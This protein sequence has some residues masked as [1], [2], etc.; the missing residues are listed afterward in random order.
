MLTSE[1]SENIKKQILQQIE[2]SFPE[3]KKAQAIQQLNSMNQ[4]QLEQFILQNKLI[5]NMNQDQPCIFCQII[6]GNISSYKIAENSKAIAILE[7]NPI[8]KA[9]TIVIPKN[10]QDKN[11]KTILELSQE[12]AQQ[13]KK[14]F[15]PKDIQI[16]SSELF[17]HEILNILPI[18]KDETPNSSKQQAS[19]PELEEIQK[20]LTQPQKKQEKQLP[21]L[22]KPKTLT[23]KDTW[24]PKRTP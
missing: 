9:H 10:H 22:T 6:S 24:L 13:I 20:I 5:K 11:S 12:V 19:Q 8:S 3:D 17:D 7:I 4:K 23:D 1:Q 18:Y 2:S 14:Q 15:N 21:E 16:Y